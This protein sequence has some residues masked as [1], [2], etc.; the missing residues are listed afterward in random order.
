MPTLL[1]LLL[2]CNPYAETAGDSGPT[3]TTG[4]AVSDCDPVVLAPPLVAGDEGAPADPHSDVLGGDP[5]PRHVRL[6]WPSRDPSRTAGFI[7]RTDLDTMASI[8]EYG[9]GTNLDQRAEGYTFLAGSGSS[10]IRVH[11][12]RLCGALQPSTTYS[13]RVGGDGAWSPTYQFTTPGAPGSFDTFRVTIAGDSRGAYSTWGTLLGLMEAEQP[14]FYIFSGDMVDRGTSQSEWDAW[15]DASE[16]Y[17]ARKV[18]VPAH[19]NHEGLAQAYF[20]QWM[21][22]NNEEWFA[23]DYGNLRL[24][25]L[26]DTVRDLEYLETDQTRFMDEQLADYTGE[27]SFAMHHQ[28]IYSTC[29]R[30]GSYEELRALWAPK[31]DEYGVDVVFAGHNH[32][33]ERSVPI[34]A[35]QEQPAGQ[36][37]VYVVSG[38]AGAPLYPESEAEWFGTVANPV[39]H[40]VVADVTAAHIAFTAKDISGNVIDTFTVP[41]KG[42]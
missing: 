37:T 39:E 16:G 30:H 20:A 1:A 14:D 6:S 31:F 21:L 17:L 12:V 8:V 29:T 10:E 11:E 9:V 41:A 22:P 24:L 4:T 3:A 18:F 27:W 40:Y 33:Y 25:S 19:G 28:P 32:I 34:K 35:D 42:R 13:Y 15:L 5:A 26:N 36:G 23:I 2:A 7:W 38:G